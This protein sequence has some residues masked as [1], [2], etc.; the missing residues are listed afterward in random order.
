[1]LTLCLLVLELFG[2]MGVLGVR[3]SA[4]PA[5][6]LVMAVGIG[7]EFTLHI[8][9]VSTTRASSFWRIQN[10]FNDIYCRR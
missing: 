8:S 1:M 3:L 7:L 2:L 6:I 4:I 9:M 10:F 5:V